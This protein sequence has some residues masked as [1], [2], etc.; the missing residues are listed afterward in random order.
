MLYFWPQYT[1]AV[2]YILNVG[3]GMSKHGK[4][5]TGNESVWTALIGSSVGAVLLYYGGFWTGAFQ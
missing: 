4:P 3:I 2:L 5:K 1:I